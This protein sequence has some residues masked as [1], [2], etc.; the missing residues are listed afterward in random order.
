MH[1]C[2]TP[3]HTQ[4]HAFTGL[5]ARVA[6]GVRLIS[7]RSTLKASVAGL[8]GLSLPG[9]LASREAAAKA[10]MPLGKKSCIL[11]WM[12]GGPSQIDTL[13]PKPEAPPEIR[14]PFET[15][16]TRL[17]GIRFC[18]HLPKIAGMM[19][20]L[21][22]IRSVD[23]RFSNHE[24]NM[25]MQTANL[26]NE[27]RTN[28]E[29]KHYPA[30]ASLVAKF[31][32]PNDKAMPPYVVL[33]MKSKSHVAFAGDAGKQYEPLIGNDVERLFQPL[34]ELPQERMRT[35]RDLLTQF[36]KL[37]EGLD[38]SGSMEALD[39]Y[40]RQAIEMVSGP[41]ARE[42]FD[43][44]REP[45]RTQ[46]TYGENPW[47]QQALLARR[48]VEAGVNFVTIDLSN[49]GASGTW[50]THG[51]NIPPYGGISK[52]LRPLL[53]IFD[54]LLTTLISDLTER[55]LDKDV[56]VIAMGEF[57]RTPQIGTQGS[58]DGR[59]HWPYVMSMTLAG[60]GLRHGQVIGATERD[61]GHIAERPITP[62]DIAATI[63]RHFGVPDGAQYIDYRG[64]PRFLQ[65]GGQVIAELF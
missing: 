42:A 19:D 45:E 51:D 15:I 3:Q 63:Y 48:L 30:I 52:G 25:V 32:G 64:R 50:D 41:K 26:A 2:A 38:L 27:P 61:A 1:R 5:N 6:E 56:L 33:N 8:A 34:A 13:D 62:A 39:S 23:C 12:T 4:Q 9:L 43:L 58:T 59:N 29:A 44:S 17:P 46:Q 22:V 37:R 18:E 20:K 40:S 28:P 16:A 35:R 47:C 11:I 54:H 31:R 65:E 14:G 24:P 55:G 7:R 60:G 53:P 36:D 49:H 21:T 10:G 57:G